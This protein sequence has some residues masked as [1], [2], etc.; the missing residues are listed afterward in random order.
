MINSAE[1]VG[2]V[3]Q[4]DRWDDL[5][6]DA[7]AEA[8]AAH[9]MR[10]LSTSPSESQQQLREVPH[11]LARAGA[12]DRLCILLTSFTFLIAR[13]REASP[14]DLINDFDLFLDPEL[15]VAAE[16]REDA[17]Q[18]QEVLRLSSHILTY[19]PGQLPEQLLKRLSSS[20]TPLIQ[21]L[22]ANALK[23]K[24][25]TWL[26]PLAVS[27]STSN[28]RLLRTMA[29]STGHIDVVAVMPD[30]QHIVAANRSSIM[31]WDIETGQEASRFSIDDEEDITDLV[32]SQDGEFILATFRDGT[33]RIW[34]IATGAEIRR[35]RHH[36]RAALTLGLLPNGHVV[37]GGT[38]GM[39][40]IWDWPS[41][42]VIRVLQGSVPAIH[43]LAITPDGR[44]AVTGGGSPFGSLSDQLVAVWDLEA[45]AERRT[46]QGHRM[47]VEAI[48]LSP[49]G[50]R[51][52]S[53]SMDH[54]LRVWNMH[55]GT[56]D[57]TL[58]GHHALVRAVCV[59]PD[60][61]HAISAADDML[62]VWDLASGHELFS[63]SGHSALVTDVAFV[64]GKAL[65]V[66]TSWDQTIRVWNLAAE[67]RG[68]APHHGSAISRIVI[69][70][71][72]RQAISAS[73]DHTLKVWDL[74]QQTLIHTIA[75]HTE[76]VTGVAIT[77]D[78][79]R[80][81]SVSWDKTIR[82]WDLVGGGEVLCVEHDRPIYALALSSD[83]RVAI[84]ASND[85]RLDVWELAGGTQQQVL[86]GH[87]GEIADI[88]ITPDQR[89]VISA[90]HDGS[91]RVWDLKSS[92]EL[93]SYE[94]HTHGV[95][96]LAIL[97]D[98]RVLSASLDQTLHL[99][100]SRNGAQL[101]IMTGSS[102]GIAAVAAA[103]G[104]DRIVT[105]GGLPHL[106]S[107]N[108]VRLWDLSTPSPIARAI[109]DSPM[110]ACAI[111]PDGTIVVAGDTLGYLHFYQ[112]ESPPQP[113][114]DVTRPLPLQ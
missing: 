94:A 99:W 109:S 8:L 35:L 88:A 84:T 105:A 22:R 14:Q 82:C 46:L 18:I 92:Q 51:I 111:T 26:R 49:D 108:T 50:E 31:I 86:L 24:L 77:A 72:G 87:K 103:T 64:P 15:S 102:C 60:G 91:A 100:N 80:I 56:L 23:S 97:D 40:R 65:L 112:V 95:T 19:S 32:V 2:W 68:Q 25:A 73:R 3:P 16:F 52:I 27:P 104:G 21:A 17:R 55:D 29:G 47:P 93:G 45:G 58:V 90:S 113:A 11:Y 69:T 71:D 61:A 79:S 81:V 42:T 4:N 114:R 37:S 9:Y 1:I 67:P 54:T 43:C 44:A 48:T 41:G 28:S 53:A 13:L 39:L 110:T 57:H 30:A 38:D 66:S 75:G 78:G 107:D 76:R 34:E 36:E 98:E 85:H 89:R 83:G 6:D 70:P 10:R 106:I 62:K 20:S 5:V 12:V 59:T 7:E 33:V 96:S 63:L 101:A 74:R